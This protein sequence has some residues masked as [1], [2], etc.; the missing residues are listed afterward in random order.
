VLL[1]LFAFLGCDALILGL[2]RESSSQPPPAVH[3]SFDTIRLLATVGS[4]SL[5]LCGLLGVVLGSLALY[6]GRRRGHRPIARRVAAAAL[7]L[8]TLELLY[9]LASALFF[10]LLSLIIA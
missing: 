10:A 2:T 7:V 9:W 3:L 5:L 1:G 6:S 4:Y 8:G